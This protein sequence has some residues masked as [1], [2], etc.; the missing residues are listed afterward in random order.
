MDL[1]AVIAIAYIG[2]PI[3]ALC[4]LIGLLGVWRKKQNWPAILI[5]AGA[6]LLAIAAGLFIELANTNFGL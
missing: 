5:I 2:G 1:I 3:G 6:V 4:V